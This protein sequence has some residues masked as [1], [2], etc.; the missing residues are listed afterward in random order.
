MSMLSSGGGAE[1]AIV[2]VAAVGI[3]HNVKSSGSSCVPP[4]VPFRVITMS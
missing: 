1:V 4:S 3:F 2:S